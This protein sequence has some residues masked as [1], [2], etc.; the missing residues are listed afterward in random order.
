MG[1]GLLSIPIFAEAIKRCDAV[2]KPKGVDIYEIITSDDPNIFDNIVHAFVG[3]IAVQ[4]DI[5]R[6]Y[7]FATKY[8]FLE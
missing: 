6:S 7:F 8:N 5:S 4:V 2:L 1:K 3:I